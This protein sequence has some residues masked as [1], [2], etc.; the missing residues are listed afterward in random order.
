MSSWFPT[1]E[2]L[3]G[4]RVELPSLWPPITTRSQSRGLARLLAVAIEENLPL[5]PLL[6]EWG[7]EERGLQR[8]RVRRLVQLLRAGRPLPD[9]LE[10]IPG[11]LREEEAL[12]VRF[13]AQSGTRT[14]AVRRFIDQSQGSAPETQR[15]R[16]T[17]VYLTVVLGAA[18]LIFLFLN[19]KTV[20]ALLKIVSEFQMQTPPALR[21]SADIARGMVDYWWLVGL[22]IVGLLWLIY[23]TTAGRL[24]RH[25]LATRLVRPL[26]NLHAALV[27]DSL[28]VAAAAGRPLAGA[29]STLAR[30]H[31]AADVRHKLLYVRNEVEQGAGVWRSMQDMGLLSAAEVRALATADRLGN[32]EWVLKKLA[33][34]KRV[35]TRRWLA[36]MS[37]LV[38]P[39]GVIAFGVLVVLMALIVFQPLIRLIESLS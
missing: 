24:L 15:A 25:S 14:A 31:F 10:D 17:L 16:R 6:D 12:A 27:L 1:F 5:A 2:R 32:R 26:R 23:S 35:R 30:H 18:L 39:A 11:I 20:P 34:T 21:W 38:L 4:W 19:L 29:L 36:R 9:A 7:R 37:E 8:R 3:A 22:G 33:E 13:D 28:S